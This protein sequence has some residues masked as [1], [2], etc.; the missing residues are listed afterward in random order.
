M[1]DVLIAGGDVVL[2]TTTG[3][4]DIGVKGEHIAVCAAPGTLNVSAAHVVEAGGCLVVPGGIDPHVHTLWTHGGGQ[5]GA[6]RPTIGSH[7]PIAATAESSGA[8][9]SST[10]VVNHPYQ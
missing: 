10:G 4:W 3:R 5:M 8:S 1:L 2:P 9:D 7:L 6:P